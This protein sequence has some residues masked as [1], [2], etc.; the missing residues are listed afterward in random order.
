M[1]QIFEFPHCFTRIVEILHSRC[2]VAFEMANCFFK[3]CFFFLSWILLTSQLRSLLRRLLPLLFFT[4]S[5]GVVWCAAIPSMTDTLMWVS[6]Q[7]PRRFKLNVFVQMWWREAKHPSVREGASDPS[8]ST[9][10]PVTSAATEPAFQ[11]R[12]QA[13]VLSVTAKGGAR[14]PMMT[15]TTAAD[16]FPHHRC[17][18]VHNFSPLPD[19]RVP[20][21]PP[22]SLPPCSQSPPASDD[23]MSL[24]GFRP[25][26]CPSRLRVDDAFECN[27][28]DDRDW[29]DEM[30]GN[31]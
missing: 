10:T 2:R 26:D 21:T 25:V 27:R 20:T 5:P 6:A 30:N 22:V 3:C 17:R 9:V 24:T 18:Q 23:D 16:V 29:C 31:L 4:H 7:L 28:E 14:L 8:P 11:G 15:T 13:P 12:L 1:Q 19:V